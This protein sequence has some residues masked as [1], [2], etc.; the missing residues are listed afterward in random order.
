[1]SQIHQ[2]FILDL[3]LNFRYSVLCSLENFRFWNFDF[4]HNHMHLFLCNNIMTYRLH[5]D[6][7]ETDKS[8]WLWGN[9][10]YWFKV[11]NK[12]LPVFSSYTCMLF[13]IC[14][15]KNPKPTKPTTIWTY[16]T[17]MLLRLKIL[18]LRKLPLRW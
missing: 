7:P 10:T 5:A 18:K 6:L 4:L 2:D 17:M 8:W 11:L 9:F 1:M 13:N 3:S 16:K 12:R 14:L 15:Y